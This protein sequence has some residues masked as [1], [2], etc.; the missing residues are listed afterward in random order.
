MGSRT[1]KDIGEY[2]EGQRPVADFGWCHPY[3]DLE[4][5]MNTD[6]A[7]CPWPYRARVPALGSLELMLQDTALQ[8]CEVQP[9]VNLG[10]TGISWTEGWHHS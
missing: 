8:A 9:L 3:T 5:G 2:A 7:G 10:K 4:E 6:S 1:C